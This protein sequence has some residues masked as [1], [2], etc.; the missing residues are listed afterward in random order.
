MT[1]IREG[2]FALFIVSTFFAGCSTEKTTDTQKGAKSLS[3]ETIEVPIDIAEDSKLSLAAATEFRMS[4]VGCASGHSLN[5]IDES[6]ASISVYKGDTDCLVKLDSFKTSTGVTYTPMGRLLASAFSEGSTI[7]FWSS[8]DPS[9]KAFVTVAS[10]L[11]SP[12]ASDDRISFTFVRMSKG[13][14][15]SVSTEGNVGT[16]EV[17]GD[18]APKFQI[19]TSSMVSI[20]SDGYGMFEFTLEC[21]ELIK[22][23]MCG[24]S[25]FS[26]LS[27]LLVAL[28]DTTKFVEL[29]LTQANTYFAES[30]TSIQNV[31]AFDLTTGNGGFKTHALKGPSPLSDKNDMLFI[32]RSNGSYRYYIID[33]NHI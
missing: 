24:N 15:K 9:E 28:D 16:L 27:Y 11:S 23:D 12:I 13:E 14:Q 8:V 33:V 7:A 31:N 2:I 5:S 18:E 6:I 30:T 10:Q 25:S 21:E 19:L 1:K 22:V 32:L 4:L 26:E 3:L 20:S 17:A 29:S